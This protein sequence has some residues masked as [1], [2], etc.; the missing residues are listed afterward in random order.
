M[1]RNKRLHF[2]DID[3]LRAIAFLPIYIF[4]IL[5][6]IQTQEE[7]MIY[8]AVNLI[9]YSALS[10][11]DFFFVIAAF[12]ATSNGLREHKYL[13]SFSFKDFLIRRII[14]LLPILLI[15]LLFAFLIHP[16]LV[17]V[18]ALRPILEHSSEYYRSWYSLLFRN[19]LFL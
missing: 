3:G 6:L 16:W 15:G 9:R 12:L 17:K 7:G 18:L 19:R 11:M 2:K 4:C 8:E 10:S 14:R 13:Q 5:K 1:P